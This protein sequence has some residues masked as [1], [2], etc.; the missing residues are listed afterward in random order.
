MVMTTMDNQ[1]EKPTRRG[2]LWSGMS[3]GN[4]LALLARNGFAVDRSLWK[5]ALSVAATATLRT[6]IGWLAHL[7]YGGQVAATT[8]EKPPLFILGH[9]RSGTTFLHEL[10]SLD[11]RHTS[12]NTFECIAP[13]QFL[14]TEKRMLPILQKKMPRQRPM[15]GM[16]V[17]LDRPQEDE[18]ALCNMGIPSPYLTIAFPRHPPAFPEYLDLRTLDEAARERWKNALLEFLQRV[19]LYRGTQRRLVLKSPTHTARVRT[20]LELFPGARFVFLVRDPYLVFASTMHMFDAL[21]RTYGLQHPPFPGL[22][23]QVLDTYLRL[24][25]AFEADRNLIPPGQLV[26]LRYEDLVAEPSGV[27]ADLYRVLDLG[28]YAAVAPAV[29][30]QLQA[31]AA[32]KPNRHALPDRVVQLVNDHWGEYIDRYGYQRRCGA[33]DERNDP[34]RVEPGEGNDDD[35]P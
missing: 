29:E 27:L 13:N 5:D 28:E 34:L 12:P 31:L 22:E 14:L 33:Q 3:L 2:G 21:Y 26:A 19:T 7:V 1:H 17:G 20:L 35:R 15:D 30:R 11:E 18:F 8:I 4:W 24:H 23:E 10:L 32:Y 6:P 16:E 9:W 25:A